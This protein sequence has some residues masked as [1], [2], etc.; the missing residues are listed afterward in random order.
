MCADDWP[1]S[2]HNRAAPHSVVC[3]SRNPPD[4]YTSGS[5]YSVDAVRVYGH[6]LQFV[7]HQPCGINVRRSCFV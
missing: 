4:C 2:V 6:Q 5:N 7:W 3:S 1:V